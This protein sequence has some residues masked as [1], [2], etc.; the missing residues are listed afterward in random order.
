MHTT[1]KMITRFRHNYFAL[2]ALLAAALFGAI[3]ISAVWTAGTGRADMNTPL[4]LITRKIA[5]LFTPAPS[6]V[7]AGSDREQLAWLIFLCSLIVVVAT[8]L[9]LL[10]LRLDPHARRSE[11]DQLRLIVAQLL[12]AVFID[13]VLLN[14]VVAAQLGGLVRLRTALAWL[15]IQ[16]GIGFIADGY[17]LV[18]M[19]RNDALVL[20][21]LLSISLERLVQV[22]AFGT[23]Y[24]AGKE[25]QSRLSLAAANA[26]LRA[27][28]SLLGEMVRSSE[29]MRIAR[30]LHDVVGHHLTALNLHLDLALRQS[31]EKAASSL[32]TS[33]Q[34]AT[35]L[36]AEVRAMVGSER[37]DQ[38]IELRL[39][40]QT[41][42]DGIPAPVVRLTVDQNVEIDSPALAHTLFCC[43]REAITNTVRH[44]G[45][46]VM[47]VD[48]RDRDG[49]I[50]L[51]VADDGGGGAGSIAG[52]GLQGMQ[53]R[54][55]AHGGA[56]S[57]RTLPAGGFGLVIRIPCQRAAA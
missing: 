43:V 22:L 8:V 40:L 21:L 25:R 3:E 13:S 28:Q 19:L 7:R 41:L 27:T 55:A 34:L 16:I 45:A 38:P 30:D 51:A 42:C 53:E 56:L 49:D 9:I 48:L 37:R 44:A 6:L 31:G 4:G 18:T 47:T 12:L 24:I 54:L 15:A 35:D 39:A 29:R 46:S 36:L 32:G 14:L 50:E 52:N 20:P 1:R 5:A 17:V 11:R 26:E 10:Y 57:A 2:A 33:R 23:G